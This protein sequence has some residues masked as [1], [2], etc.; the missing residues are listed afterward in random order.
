MEQNEV[1]GKVSEGALKWIKLGWT[2]SM[3]FVKIRTCKFRLRIAKKNLDAATSRLGM[4]FYS[5]H[6]RGETDILNSVAIV[7]QLKTVEEAE[8]QVLDL[9]GRMDDLGEEYSKRRDAIS[10]KQ[11]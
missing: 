8:S 7:E 6:R 5:L 9:Q 4:E 1:V 11:A 10:A 2:W 3:S